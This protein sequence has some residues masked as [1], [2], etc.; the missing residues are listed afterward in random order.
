MLAVGDAVGDDVDAAARDSAGEPAAGEP[1]SC[2]MDFRRGAGDDFV[3]DDTDGS[4]EAEA[5]LR[6]TWAGG[7]DGGVTARSSMARHTSVAF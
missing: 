1:G 2:A 7:A 3:G 6:N 4:D 5:D